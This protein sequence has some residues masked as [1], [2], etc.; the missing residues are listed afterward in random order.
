MDKPILKDPDVYPDGAV[1]INV[2]G[3]D[4]S[5]Y[6]KF[7]ESVTGPDFNIVP[8]WRYYNDGHMWLCKGV[9]KKK[10]VFWLS[11]WDGCFKT[12][13]YFAERLSGGAKTLVAGN[14]GF[15]EFG[16][17]IPAGKSTGLIV[18]VSDESLGTVLEIAAYKMSLK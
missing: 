4:Y 1:L 9:H 12:T 18:R 13:F 3:N 14:R 10:T 6:E 11:V 5:A 8:E 16:E 17:I 7:M 2:L 15:E